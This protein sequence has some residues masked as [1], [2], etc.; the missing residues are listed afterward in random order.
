MQRMPGEPVY[1]KVLEGEARVGKVLAGVEE[2][3]LKPED[4]SSPA[5][6]QMALTRILEAAMRLAS[7]GGFKEKYIA[8]VRVRDDQG[9]PVII[10]V[11]LGE[12]V[13]PVPSEK[14]K[15]RVKIELLDESE[16]G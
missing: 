11:D 2:L 10:I 9:R 1:E 3:M 8:E 12:S 6:L 5:S 4:L 15:A 16:E 13:P 7:Q 14:V